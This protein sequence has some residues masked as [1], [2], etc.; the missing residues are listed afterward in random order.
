MANSTQTLFT[1]LRQI[2]VNVITSINVSVILEIV[3]VRDNVFSLKGFD[4]NEIKN[5]MAQCCTSLFNFFANIFMFT[6]S[7][8][9]S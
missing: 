4:A 1:D 3:K 9:Q 5:I 7:H 2:T 8:V 6:L